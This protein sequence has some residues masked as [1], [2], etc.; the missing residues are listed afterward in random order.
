[1]GQ[2]I[3][4]LL[5]SN[6][7]DKMEIPEEIRQMCE[8]VVIDYNAHQLGKEVTNEAFNLPSLKKNPMNI[9]YA[10]CLYT[11]LYPHIPIYEVSN[12]TIVNM[13]NGVKRLLKKAYTKQCALSKKVKPSSPPTDYQRARVDVEVY[14]SLKNAPPSETVLVP[15]PMPV[16]VSELKDLLPFYDRLKENTPA[17]AVHTDSLGSYEKFNKGAYYT[18]G[19]IDLCKQVVGPPHIGAL[20]DSIKN[21]QNVKHFLL[22][23]NIIGTKGAYS[24]SEFIRTNSNIET[25]YLAGNCIDADGIKLIVDALMS[26]PS[27]DKV[28]QLWL[29]RNP[30]GPDGAIAL[31]HYLRSNPPLEVLDLT[32]T[33]IGDDG[34][35]YLFNALENN[36]NLKILYLD[37]NALTDKCTYVMA[38][39]F[40][41]RRDEIGLTKLSLSINRIGDSGVNILFS[42]LKFYKGLEVLA[43]GSNRIEIDGL[44]TI[45]KYVEES[46]LQSLD[47]GYYKSTA[48]MGELPNSFGENGARLIA[49]CIMA[50]TPLRNLSISNT[51]IQDIEIIADAMKHNTNLF[52]LN[53]MQGGH[54]T[55][56]DAYENINE[57]TH[58]NFAKYKSDHPEVKD[59]DVRDFLRK[60]KHGDNIWV[61][62]SIY[63]NRN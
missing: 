39:Y 1:M 46:S 30:L 28:K 49:K 33:N 7:D 61:I 2:T 48:D 52:A 51:H 15:T 20:M 37:A 4:N 35:C 56:E 44:R 22:G 31:A 40:W 57:Y 9:R 13:Y 41:S 45:L 36:T 32:N 34:C 12:E 62:D 58:R 23:N 38:S 16:D 42:G 8:R 10:K 55:P 18:D 59:D 29:K 27:R 50:N 5:F 25:W 60:L 19:R 17:S 43:L 54:V 3:S 14:K 53:C 21:N 47:I 63:R 6:P 11:L 26:E 24:I